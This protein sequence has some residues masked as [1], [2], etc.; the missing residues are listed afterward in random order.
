MTHEQRE[1]LQ[2]ARMNAPGGIWLSARRVRERERE[3][4]SRFLPVVCRRPAFLLSIMTYPH[5]IITPS[6]QTHHFI[7]GN[8]ITSRMLALSVSSITR[9]ST[10]MPKPPHGGMPYSKAVMKS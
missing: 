10:P 3:R 2:R 7:S 8:A 1:L 6:H 4:Q 9:R 5:Q